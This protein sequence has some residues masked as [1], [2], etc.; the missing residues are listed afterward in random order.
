VSPTETQPQQWGHRAIGRLFK[1]HQFPPIRRSPHY[2]HLSNRRNLNTDYCIT[3]TRECPSQA[4]TYFRYNFKAL[5][6]SSHLV[7]YI[8]LDVEPME[9]LKGR[10]RMADVTVARESDF[11]TSDRTYYVR[12]FLG[13][14]LKPGMSTDFVPINP[15]GTRRRYGPG[16]RSRPRYTR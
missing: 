12:S 14:V 11:G 8:V 5:R 13:S 9:N 15:K 4:T 7:S 10:F 6:S 1:S 16:I 2:I 3:E